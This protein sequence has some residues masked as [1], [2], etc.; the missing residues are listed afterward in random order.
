MDE[1]KITT[2]E[3][4]MT[5]REAWR[6]IIAEQQTEGKTAAVFCRE[7]GIPVWKFCYWRKVLSSVEPGGFVQMQVPTVQDTA[8]QIW[9]EAGG[10]RVCVAPGFDAPTLRRTVEALTAS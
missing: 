1:A 3:A 8:T 10:W 9:V 2:E 4:R 6:R 5:R 7:R